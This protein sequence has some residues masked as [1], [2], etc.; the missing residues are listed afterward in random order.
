[1]RPSDFLETLC[2]ITRSYDA[3]TLI[4]SIFLL[5]PF[6]PHLHMIQRKVLNVTPLSAA[7]RSKT[8][9]NNELAET[10]MLKFLS[11]NEKTNSEPSCGGQATCDR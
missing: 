6:E 5:R 4:S 10:S 2:G 9:P 8:I 7:I 3:H 11:P 1:M